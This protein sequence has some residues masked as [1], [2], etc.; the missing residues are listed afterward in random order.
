M[1]DVI[2]WSLLKGQDKL[3]S[4]CKLRS[5]L[6]SIHTLP[7]RP[8]LHRRRHGLRRIESGQGAGLRRLFHSG[9]LEPNPTE[10]LLSQGGEGRAYLLALK[11]LLRLATP[12]SLRPQIIERQSP[13]T[14][15]PRKYREIVRERER[16]KQSPDPANIWRPADGSS[17]RS[18]EAR[19]R[20]SLMAPCETPHVRCEAI[21]RW[22]WRR[23]RGMALP[24]SSP[25]MR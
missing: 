24:F 7:F 17:R 19:R 11:Q 9:V 10:A 25:P 18:G 4:P 8:S 23:W 1:G 2:L 14:Q 22:C 5:S 3:C 15:K 20:R 21:G 12:D 6:E 16:A 13:A